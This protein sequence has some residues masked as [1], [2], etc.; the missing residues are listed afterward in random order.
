[1]KKSLSGKINISGS[2]MVSKG[3][4]KKAGERQM[5]ARRAIETGFPIEKPFETPEDVEKY[6][7]GDRIVCLICGKDYNAL[8]SH[9]KVHGHTADSYKEKYRIPSNIGLIGREMF[10]K[11]SSAA[12]RGHEQGLYPNAGQ[13]TK[14]AYAAG[15]QRV[16][17]G[18]K[19]V[20]EIENDSK[21]ASRLAAHTMFRHE[22]RLSKTHCNKGHALK[23]I[24]ALHCSQCT[25]L[26]VKSQPYYSS[27]KEAVTTIVEVT[28]TECGKATSCKKISSTRQVILC[29]D[30]KKRKTNEARDRIRSAPGYRSAEYQRRKAKQA[31]LKDED[32]Y[33][34]PPRDP[35]KRRQ[36]YLKRKA[37]LA[38][39]KES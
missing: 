12:K 19:S 34:A 17:R 36:E 2:L 6:L 37:R 29:V 15:K 32:K 25:K 33:I 16:S 26:W 23:E 1:M 28:C 20:K 39:E 38:K 5:L 14:E 22:Q 18:Y 11:L 27:R 8:H 9:L 21:K 31:S 10:D 3:R 30:C 7:S 13:A 24:G 4:W 35:E